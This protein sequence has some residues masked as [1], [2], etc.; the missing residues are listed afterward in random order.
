MDA[1][2]KEFLAS[3]RTLLLDTKTPRKVVPAGRKIKKEDMGLTETDPYK[4]FVK[5]V[6][7]EKPKKTEIVKELKRFAEAAEANL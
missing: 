4:N 1:T 2:F 6:V 7:A 3:G 5:R